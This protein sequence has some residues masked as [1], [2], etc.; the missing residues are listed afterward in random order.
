MSRLSEIQRDRLSL[1]PALFADAPVISEDPLKDL[2]EEFR[3]FE[4]AEAVATLPETP[5]TV[6]MAMREDHAWVAL[7]KQLDGLRG[8]LRRLNYYLAD[9][10]DN[11][12]R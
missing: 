4:S 6:S 7:E 5:A 1:V 12:R 9:V 8:T 10:D 11:L 2:L 3:A